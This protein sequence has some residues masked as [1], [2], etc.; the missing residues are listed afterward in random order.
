MIPVMRPLLV[1]AVAATLLA[2]PPATRRDNV[3]ETLHGVELVD[4]YRWLEDQTSAETRAWID[5]QN[6]YTR[7]ILDKA[8]GRDVL[9][10]RFTA[11]LRLDSLTVPRA[12]G[13]RYF[14]RRR[15]ADQEQHVLLMRPTLNGPDEI[16]V[17]P[18]KLSSDNSVSVN[19]VDMSDDGSLVGYQIQQGGKDEARVRFLQVATREHL[20]DELAEGKYGGVALRHDK[21]GFFYSRIGSEKP[22]VYEHVMGKPASEDREIFGDG[23]GATHIPTVQISDNGRWLV[24]VVYVG[25]SGD[26]T[27]V[28]VKDLK[29]N[30]PVRT[31]AKGIPSGFF[32]EF[33]GDRLLLQTNWK[34]PRWRIVEVDLARPQPE[35]W[36]EVIPEGKG[37]LEGFSLTGGRIV[38]NSLE[39]VKSR[40][41]IH[42]LDG[43]FEREIP[44]P[45][46]GSASTAIGRFSSSEAFFLF[47][48]FHIPN[49][50]YRYDIASGKLDV[51]FKLN[52]P[53]RSEDFE[54]KQVWYTSKDGTRIP[55]A[56]LHK[57]G[58][59]LDG[60][61]PV[62]LSGY[63]GFNVANT[64]TFSSLG[65]TFAE[66]GGIY[67][68]ANLRGGAEYGE[69]WHRA[70]ML[71]KKQNVFD[72]FIAAA[73]YLIANKYTKSSRLAVEGSSNGGLLVGAV[74]TQRP[75]LFQAVLCGYPLLDMVR[76]HKFLVARFWVPEYG[77][78]DDPKQF[79][80]LRAYSPYHNVKPG[81]KYPATMI[82]T[83]DADTRVAPLH[84]RKMAALLQ[85]ATGSD[86][87]VLL[88]YD[89]KA[90]HSGGMSVTKTIDKNVDIMSF[91]IQQ[92][93]VSGE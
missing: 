61:R 66:R 30:G 3:K 10:K 83:G 2:A 64:P 35:N 40:L 26:V 86:R 44:L 14:L 58:L 31:I 22:R 62:L 18:H 6:Q 15:A 17:D 55:M 41:K 11:L 19:F 28:F 45:S 38:V 93:G 84:G 88:H 34:A 65:V 37:V 47:Q 74:M 25:S 50:I 49:Q 43:K 68:V 12:R 70:G 24:I 1:T 78:S 9:R 57:K 75:E 53:I 20:R 63:G 36:K 46:I 51:W 32:P 80:Y 52:V 4:P 13:G 91:L 27:E 42:A 39:D 16:L 5:A 89:V 60:N 73:V 87:P 23:Y 69:E 8:P 67:A 76:Y 71:D 77:S 7:S 21:S 81:A 90:G 54:V 85:A 92:L 59:S 33:A 48:S 56:L 72:D 82:I 29:T 79:A